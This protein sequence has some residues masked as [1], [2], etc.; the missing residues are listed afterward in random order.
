[1]TAADNPF[2]E[3]CLVELMGHRRVAAY[4]TE[5]TLAGA[6]MLRLD[7][8]DGRTQYV[9]P[10]SVYALHPTTEDVVRAMAGQWR[11]PPITRYELEQAQAADDPPPE[12]AS[13]A[14]PAPYANPW[15]E[16]EPP[17]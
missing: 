1:M 10:T 16:P 3:W 15:G 2:A 5:I 8:P 7:E 13:A 14:G 6:G 12:P 17:F 11:E 9:S 4:V